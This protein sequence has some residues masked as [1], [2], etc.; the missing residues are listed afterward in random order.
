MTNDRSGEVRTVIRNIYVCYFISGALGLA[1]QVLWLRKLLLVFGST[2][3]AVS[4]VLTVF[5]G[6]LALGSWWFGKRIDRQE[7]KGLKWY[8][9][10]EITVGVYAFLTPLLF[11]GIQHLYI[12]IYRASNFSPLVLVAASFVCAALILLPPTFLLGGTF[13]VLSRFLIR[14]SEERG[15][16]IAGLYGINTAGAMVGTILVYYV[17]FPILGFFRTLVCAGVLNLGVGGLCLVFD[18]HLGS[19]GFHPAPRPAPPPAEPAAEAPETVRWLMIA[20]ALSG[21][22]AMVYEVTWTRALSLVLGSSIYAFCLMLATFLGGIALGSAW[23]RRDLREGPATVSQFIIFEAVLGVYGLLS[24][25]LLGQMPDWFVS[26]WPLT[27]GS[28]SGVSTLQV[29]LSVF[30]MILPTLAM[31]LLFPIVT[32]LMTRQLSHLGRR[33]GNIYAV[34]TLGGIIGS[35]LSGF[36]LIP[37]FGL[38][39]AIVFAGLVN[40]IAACILYLRFGRGPSP[41]RVGVSAAGLLVAVIASRVVILPSWQQESLAAGVYIN[42]A[43]YQNIS[44]AQGN[45]GVKTLFYRDSLNAT[46]SVH[47]QDDNLFLKVGGKTDASTGLDMGTQVLSAHIPL[48]LR[49]EAKDVLVIG[50]GSGITLGSAG[51]HPVSRLDCAEI[52]PAVIEAAREFFG[53]YNHDVHHDPRTAMYAVDGRNFLLAN[54]RRYDVI[55][56]EPSNPWM[57]G[58]AYL[59]TKEFY[60]LAKRRLAPGGVMCQWLQLYRIF[61]SDVKLVLKTFHSEFPYVTVWSSIPGDLLLVGSMEPQRLDYQRLAEVMAQPKIHDSLKTV[62][63]ERPDVLLDLYWMGNQ[64]LEQLTADVTWIHEDDQPWLE[65]SAPKALYADPTSTAN[66]TGLQAFK[67]TPQAIAPAYDPA[68]EDARHFFSVGL[69]WGARLQEDKAIEALERA[70]ALDP[71]MSEAWR[72]LGMMHARQRAWLK[73][74]EALAKAAQLSPENVDVAVAMARLQREQGRLDQAQPLYDRAAR[75][76]I[77]DAELTEEIG[78][79]LRDGR[80]FSLAAEYFRSAVSQSSEPEHALIAAYGDALKESQAADTEDVLR[81]GARQF[82]QDGRFSFLL[83]DVLLTQGRTEEARDAFAQGLRVAPKRIE[84]YY[85][86]GRIAAGRGLRTEAV[87]MLRRG[88]LFA[89]Y[90]RDALKLL[91]QLAQDHT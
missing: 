57:A 52:E 82:P 40:L 75:L 16:K 1:Y 14:T 54:D 19:L 89:P 58:L 68:V 31:G 18:R 90:H 79:S 24:V 42:P 10:L 64:E 28:F 69:M 65:F 62:Q 60:Q 39:W 2:V 86:L 25:P 71:S 35:F 22:S 80:H 74:E 30:V 91:A 29:L 66:F 3:Y 6:G 41:V 20:F 47:Q 11:A 55:I 33:V 12:P 49:P 56:S 34:N 15:V 36:F 50:L 45:Q 27:G 17:G 70:V 63:V 87:R 84:G 61:P 76:A 23:A 59:F 9:L 46:V 78:R 81:F 7:S 48:L 38:P 4:T 72:Q 51:R 44:V 67:S 37:L 32:D 21:F 5:F 13:P 73:A 85:G 8:A 83:G 88:L 26:L 53:R 77:P 43:T